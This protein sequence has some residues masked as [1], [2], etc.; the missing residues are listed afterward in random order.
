M[1]L[2]PYRYALTPT[3]SPRSSKKIGV[4]KNSTT[5]L[6]THQRLLTDSGFVSGSGSGSDRAGATCVCV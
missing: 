4:D 1:W 2:N 6:K 5:S 3:N